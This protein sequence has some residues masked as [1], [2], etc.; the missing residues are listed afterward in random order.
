M[1]S[2]AFKE[3][4]TDVVDACA[5]A[6]GIVDTVR[7]PVLVLDK[8]LRVVAASRSFYSVFKVSPENTQGRHLYALGDGQWDIPKLRELLEKIIPQHGVMESYE[9]EHEFPDLG[10]RRICLNARQVFYE[11]G[12]GATI[13]LGME[14]VTAQHALER[15]KDELLKQKDVLLDELQHRISN[16]LQII[17]SII[18]MK[19][20]TVESEETRVHLQDAHKRVMSVAAVQ[21]QLH[22]SGAS[23]PIEMVPYLSR[24]CETL[25][26]SMIGDTR[27]ISLKVVGA[28]GRATP[29]QAESLGLIVTELVM[30]ALKHAFPDDKVDGRIS[31]AYEVHGTNWKL[32]VADNGIGKPDDVFAQPKTGLGTGIVKALTQQLGAT[33][34][35]SASL[36][37][38]TV[39]ITHATFT[40]DAVHTA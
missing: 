3:Q 4:F 12:A 35:T 11:H 2:T 7:E 23:G 38:T 9:V 19:A 25:A 26:T 13:L 22:G 33:V 5:L 24:L 27:P 18:L 6:Q 10:H 30:N 21:Q 8:E 37:G 39:A 16:S 40:T 34:E 29:R 14:D 17:A 36:A 15:E 31:V 1:H 32:S 20:K 28:G